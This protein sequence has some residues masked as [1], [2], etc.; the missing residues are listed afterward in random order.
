[1]RQNPEILAWG[2]VT[3]FRK[4]CGLR[5]M[6][7]WGYEHAKCYQGGGIVVPSAPSRHPS[8]VWPGTRSS[9]E[10]ASGDPAGYILDVPNASPTLHACPWLNTQPCMCFLSASTPPTTAH[11]ETWPPIP[12]LTWGCEQSGLSLIYDVRGKMTVQS[13]LLQGLPSIPFPT[14]CSLLWQR[15]R[16]GFQTGLGG[17]AA[18]VRKSGKVSLP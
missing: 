18:H 2:I 9:Q 5:V 8:K 13:G 1:M 4:D 12:G 6:G 15:G 16:P 10:R 11:L 14:S 7:T 3:Y 17:D